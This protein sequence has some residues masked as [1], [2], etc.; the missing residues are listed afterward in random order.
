MLNKIE[1]YP[2]DRA[3]YA[4]STRRIEALGYTNDLSGL[5][6]ALR[7]AETGVR[8]EAAFLLGHSEDPQAK[9]A[10]DA[11]LQD[12]EARVRVEAAFALARLGDKGSAMS[13]LHKELQGQ[14]FSDAPLRAA[15][16]LARLGD[17]VGYGRVM[18][19]LASPL[20]SNR[21]EA[22]AVLSAFLPY[23]GQI[24]ESNTVD[25]VAVLMKGAQD[26][27]ELL[28]R[29]ALSALASISDPR[30][31]PF[32]RAATKDKEPAVRNLARSLLKQQ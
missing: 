23:A 5:I 28:R 13:T 27:E 9:E 4:A 17:P 1:P 3:R 29:D 19:A 26:P 32:L 22:I 10:L 2:E 7:H 6:S 31:K 12:N 11:S 20:P 18:E 21:M 24:V 15:R 16:A 14:F 8:A 30:V 25:P